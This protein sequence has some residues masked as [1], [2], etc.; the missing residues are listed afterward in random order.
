M[1][2]RRAF[3]RTIGILAVLLILS[4]ALNIA[5]IIMLSK[6]N[7]GTNAAEPAPT[8]EMS[9]TAEPEQP[10]A[11]PTKRP[12]RATPT[13]VP[14]ETSPWVYPTPIQT[15][16]PMDTPAATATAVPT[17]TPDVTGGMFGGGE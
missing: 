16:E 10:T 1:R 13:P 3:K 6:A 2:T 7:G 11:K 4:A 5:L 8:P 17:P 12:N 14:T 9:D 15:A